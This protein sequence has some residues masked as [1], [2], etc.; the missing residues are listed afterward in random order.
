VAATADLLERSGDEDAVSIR[1]IA[2]AVGVSPP[3][4]YL[5]FP[6][7]TALLF[8]VC[9]AR[10]L[11]LDQVMEAAAELAADPVDEIIRRGAAYIRFGLDHPEQY[12]ILFM[13][14]EEPTGFSE[15]HLADA[16]A[17]DHMVE[18]VTRAMRAGLIAD[19][20]PVVVTIGLWAAVHGITSLLI[21][22][23][24]FP[25]PPVDELTDQVLS[26]CATGVK[27]TAAAR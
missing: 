23:P 24:D 11:Q 14:R 13:A 17:F 22:K 8:A 16:S 15:E 26:M 1:A 19:G 12:R 27:G 6:D 3:S 10:F 20:D 7:K 9:Q 4:I 25:W 5:H 18:A 21:A 2:D